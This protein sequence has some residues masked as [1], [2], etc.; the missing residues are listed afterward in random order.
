M[1]KF[2]ATTEMVAA[3]ANA[4]KVARAAA[5]ELIVAARQAHDSIVTLPATNPENGEPIVHGA[6]KQMTYTRDNLL[7]GFNALWIAVGRD[8][9]DLL[10]FKHRYAGNRFR[11]DEQW[12]K[13]WSH[14]DGEIVRLQKLVDE[15][16]D[17]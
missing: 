17:T 14:L 10:K 8:Y 4:L 16:K 7:S 11:S 2:N 1:E 13:E 6:N 9:H 12:A 3:R 15:G 5:E